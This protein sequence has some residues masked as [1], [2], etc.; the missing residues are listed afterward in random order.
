VEYD[1]KREIALVANCGLE[2]HMGC[3]SKLEFSNVALI[4]K[5][6]HNFLPPAYANK[7]ID[8]GIRWM[9]WM[10]EGDYFVKEV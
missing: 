1:P 10:E 8:E 2:G 9:C 6:W 7:S 5:T 4:G 3:W